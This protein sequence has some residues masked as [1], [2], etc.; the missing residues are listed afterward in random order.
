MYTNLNYRLLG[1]NFQNCVTNTFSSPFSL[2]RILFS[3]LKHNDL[4]QPSE[5]SRKNV[6]NKI[7]KTTQGPIEEQYGQR[8]NKYFTSISIQNGDGTETEKLF[9]KLQKPKGM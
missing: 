1:Y 8:E 6:Q 5:S 9:E 3:E 2:Y 4:F 7:L